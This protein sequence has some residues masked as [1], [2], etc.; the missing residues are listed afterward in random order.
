MPGIGRTIGDSL[1]SVGMALSCP[2][3]CIAPGYWTWRSSCVLFRLLAPS[4][5]VSEYPTMADSSRSSTLASLRCLSTLPVRAPDL[6]VSGTS[7]PGDQQPTYYRMP[8][9]VKAVRYGAYLH[10]KAS[11]AISNLSSLVA[12]G[13]GKGADVLGPHFVGPANRSLFPRQAAR[14]RGLGT[15]PSESLTAVLRKRTAS[16]ATFGDPDSFGHVCPHSSSLCH[17]PRA[18][19]ENRSVPSGPVIPLGKEWCAAAGGSEASGDMLG[20]SGACASGQSQQSDSATAS[21]VALDYSKQHHPAPGLQRP[22]AMRPQLQ[23][24]CSGQQ[25]Q[26][27]AVVPAVEESARSFAGLAPISNAQLSSCEP[28]AWQN[29]VGGHMPRPWTSCD[30]GI[31]A[32]A[33]AM[34]MAMAAPDQRVASLGPSSKLQ[35]WPRG[36]SP[37][38]QHGLM[39]R[40]NRASEAELVA[41]AGAQKNHAAPRKAVGWSHHTPQCLC[42]LPAPSCAVGQFVRRGGLDLPELVRTNAAAEQWPQS[43]PLALPARKQQQQTRIS[44]AHPD[45]SILG[46][47]SSINP[48]LRAAV[49]ASA[50]ATAEHWQQQ[51]ARLP[52]MDAVLKCWPMPSFADQPGENVIERNGDVRSKCGDTVNRTTLT[53]DANVGLAQLKHLLTPL[54]RRNARIRL[55]RGRSKKL[56]MCMALSLEALA[57]PLPA[58]TCQARTELWDLIHLNVPFTMRSDVE[59]VSGGSRNIGLGALAESGIG[60]DYCYTCDGGHQGEEELLGQ[61]GEV[62]AEPVQNDSDVYICSEGLVCLASLASGESIRSGWRLPFLVRQWHP[63]GNGSER[64]GGCA[65]GPPG[66][67]GGCCSAA[68]CGWQGSTPKQTGQRPTLYFA[69]PLHDMPRLLLDSWERMCANA[70]AVNGSDIPDGMVASCC[71]AAGNPCVSAKCGDDLEDDCSCCQQD[72]FQLG[73]LSLLVLSHCDLGFLNS[74][75]ALTPV[76]LVARASPPMPSV[77]PTWQQAAQAAAEVLEQRYVELACRSELLL[78]RDRTMVLYVDAADGAVLVQQHLDGGAVRN[79]AA[80]R[81]TSMK[82]HH[83]WQWLHDFLDELRS[84][85]PGPYVL[86]FNPSSKCLELLGAGEMPAQ[87]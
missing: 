32:S 85:R 37:P 69:E 10:R 9:E 76:Q 62:D 34:P 46:D 4:V 68:R 50:V 65:A 42:D 52:A 8:R 80:G 27:V 67:P 35:Q 21:D 45:G 5:I 56:R 86:I 55:D 70:L 63:A 51:L 58:D 33:G 14:P 29:L 83:H 22:A 18:V 7:C 24:T 26:R 78:G 44:Q 25:S 6:M 71:V 43:M 41:A 87:E 2:P 28:V 19:S 81:N 1:Y 15:S 11:S 73:D 47:L 75:G 20:F 17:V 53:R 39:G 64:S 16:D 84:L 59:Q 3:A 72:E 48:Q 57:T 12:L 23:N 66:A 61:S 77:G 79:L 31:H 38:A 74:V 49:A 54:P 60:D 30:V 82:L 40:T 36:Q 13:L